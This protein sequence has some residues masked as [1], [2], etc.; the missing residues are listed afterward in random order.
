MKFNKSIA[1][2]CALSVTAVYAANTNYGQ[3]R[4]SSLAAGDSNVIGISIVNQE[5]PVWAMCLPSQN[6]SY[7]LNFQCSPGD[8]SV[9]IGSTPQLPTSIPDPA[10]A[11]Y[12]Y[13]VPD[14]GALNEDNLDIVNAYAYINFDYDSGSKDILVVNNM[15]LLANILIN[16]R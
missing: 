2:I 14:T 11:K 8:S 3:N 12:T 13:D 1:I 9:V 5:L 6:L 16:N 4:Q 15:G 10:S 7:Y